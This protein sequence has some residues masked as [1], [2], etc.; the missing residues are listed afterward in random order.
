MRGAG[1]GPHPVSDV[2]KRASNEFGRKLV[3]I[4]RAE[5][6]VHLRGD[7]RAPPGARELG[8]PPSMRILIIDD[9]L[10]L[11]ATMKRA[12]AFDG[13][14]ADIAED[15]EQA[16]RLFE[17]HEYDLVI[18]DLGLPRIDG[19][20]L[21]REIRQSGSQVAVLIL[22]A[23]R[24]MRDRVLGLDVG[25]DD[26]LCKPFH[27]EELLAR[28]RALGRRERSARAPTIQVADLCIDPASMVVYKSG[29]AL[30]LTRKEFAILQYLAQRPGI[31]VSQEGLLE[32]VWDSEA[33]AFSN[34]MRVHI[35]SIRRKLGDDAR[36]PRYIA[37]VI[38]RGYK[39]VSDVPS[40]ERQRSRPEVRIESAPR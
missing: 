14:A 15:A 9:N 37:T 2:P 18:L 16:R 7:R 24:S 28:I 40:T 17:C 31:V 34:S 27:L 12:L 19:I 21:L 10:D 22:T 20:D 23:R 38:G 8:A 29:I 32:H 33:N 11:A 5:Q 30:S 26:Y 36:V 25:A 1:L 35:N 4:T 6:V 13:V 39:L 3:G